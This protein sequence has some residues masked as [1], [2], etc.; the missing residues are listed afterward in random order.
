MDYCYSHKFKTKNYNIMKTKSYLFLIITFLLS[1]A[2]E[3]QAQTNF[4]EDFNTTSARKIP[5]TWSINE[6][7]VSGTYAW[8][9]QKE[10][11]DAMC[12]R[13]N[14]GGGSYSVLRTPEITLTSDKDLSFYFK[15]ETA[16]FSVYVDVLNAD[17]SE[18]RHLLGENLV[19]ASWVLKTFSLKQFTGNKIK[20]AFYGKKTDAG[21]YAYFDKVSI[22]DVSICAYPMDIELVSVS[23]NSASIMWLINSDGSSIPTYFKIRVKDETGTIV[24]DYDDYRFENDG[25]YMFTIEGLNS[26]TLYTVS[27]CSD[28]S[29]D[30]KGVSKWSEDFEFK[31]LCDYVQLPYSADFDADNRLLSPCWIV[32]PDNLAGVEIS[33]KG[34]QYGDTGYSLMFQGST[35]K[36]AYAVSEQFAHA[37]ND[38]EISFMVYGEFGLPFNVGLTT[39]PLS[40]DAFEILVE[41]T[42]YTRSNLRWR[43]V[44]F[45][46]DASY[47]ANQENVS[48]FISLPAGVSGRL[49]VDAVRVN[50][51]PTCPRLENIKVKDILA[52]EVTLEW[53]EYGNA[54][55]YEVEMTNLFDAEASV[56]SKTVTS[57][58]CTI[59]GLVG[60]T[61]YSV[62]VRPICSDTDMGEWS[63]PVEFR[64][65]CDVMESNVFQESFEAS[66][67]TIPECWQVKQFVAG[68]GDGENYGNEGIDVYTPTYSMYPDGVT[69]TEARDGRKVLRFRKTKGGTRTAIITQAMQ[70][71]TPKS[72]DVSFW[73]YRNTR[74]I[75]SSAG[76]KYPEPI[77]V[78]VNTRPDTVGAI[79]LDVIYACM[80][81]SPT[82]EEPGWYQYDYN[83]PLTGTVYFMLEAI[84]QPGGNDLF[85][86]DIRVY[87]APTCRKIKDIELLPPTQTEF[88]M[89]WAKGND[90][91][92]WVVSYR[93]TDPNTLA[94]IKTDKVTVTGGVPEFKL[95]GLTH[96]TEY[97]IAGK[98]ASYCAV[99]DTSVWVEFDYKFMTE[100]AAISK[101]PYEEQFEGQTFPPVCWSVIGSA[102]DV[103]RHLRTDYMYQG[104]GV[105]F[106]SNNVVLVTPEFNTEA[107]KDYR[108]TFMML[109]NYGAEG[110]GIEVWLN[111]KPTLE[112][113]TKQLF[114]SSDYLGTPSVVQKAYYQY[115]VE[116]A[117]GGSKYL[118]FK[119]VGDNFNHIDNVVFLE[120]PSC[121]PILD[122]TVDN[123]TSYTARVSVL[124]EGVTTCE[125]SFCGVGVAPNAGKIVASNDSI[126]E[127]N[128]L[129]SETTYEVYVRNVCGALKGEWSSK[130]VTITT[131][132]TP[133][134]VTKATP[135]NEDF[136]SFQEAQQLAG[137]YLS[138][139]G[140]FR[141]EVRDNTYKSMIANSGRLYAWMSS[142]VSAVLYRPLKL[143]AGVYYE[144]S[145][146]AIQGGTSSHVSLGYARVPVF[147]SL[148]YVATQEKMAQEWVNHQ[149][150]F[151]VP[152]TG[153][154]YLG[155]YVYAS[156]SIGIDDIR[157]Q[158]VSCVPP[159]TN[160]ANLASNSAAIKITDMSAG[161]WL[162]S[163]NNFMFAPDMVNGNVFYGE[164][165]EEYTNLENLDPNSEY[166]YSVK[167]LCGEG[168]ESTWSKV[169]SFRT[170][171]ASQSLPFSDGFE[172]DVNCWT[173]LGDYEYHSL[174]TYPK[175]EGNQSLSASKAVI[176]TPE[177][178]VESLADYMIEGWIRSS[179]AD[180]D[181]AIGVM[182]DINDLSTYETVGTF[183]IQENSKWYHMS[184]YFSDLNLPDY[185]DF[186]NARYVV[187][188]LPQDEVSCFLDDI[189]IKLAPNCKQPVEVKLVDVTDNSCTISWTSKGE[190]T[191][192]RVVGKR[193]E[194]ISV[195]TVVTSNPA[196]IN[197]LLHSTTYDFEISSICSETESSAVTSIGKVT[198][199]CGLWDLPYVED[200]SGYSYGA[201]PLCWENLDNGGWFVEYDNRIYFPTNEKNKEGQK[202]TILT[203]KFNL[204]DVEGALLTMS[205]A[206]SYADTLTI[207]LSTDGGATY[208]IVLGEGYKNL[209]D[210][211]V[212]KFDLTPYV[213]NEIRISIEGTAS[214]IET[215]YIVINHFEIEKIESCM[216]PVGLTLKSVGGT[217]AI[218]EINDTT[219]AT[220][221]QYA[222]L[223]SNEY[224]E[225]VTEFTT[226]TTNPF[227]I[228]NLGGFTDYTLYVRTDCGD[229]QSSWRNIS[230]TTECAEVNTVP[231]FDGFEKIERPQEGCFSILTTKPNGVESWRP[232]T[233][234][235]Y[236]K[237]S[238]G[239][240]SLELFPSD[241]YEMFVVM[242]QLDAPTTSL[243]MT[244]DYL[245]QRSSYYAPDIV[246]GVL[247]DA[248]NA[249]TFEEVT[250]CVSFEPR[251]DVNDDVIFE[252]VKVEF[253]VLDAE[254]SNSRIAFKVGPTLYNQGEAYIDN[255]KI[256]KVDACPNVRSIELLEVD[257]TSARLALQY[258]SDAVQLAYGPAVQDI[259]SML[260]VV[261]TLDTIELTDLTKGVNYA[262][263]ARSVCGTD[264]GAWIH[265]LT[266][267]TVCD[268]YIID[269]ATMYSESFNSYEEHPMAFPACY[270][271][272]KTHLELGVEYPKLTKARDGE[273]DKN[274][275]H[276]YK[277]VVLAL[278]EFNLSGERLML[279]FNFCNPDGGT[280]YK[281]GL[282]EDL[283]DETTFMEVKEFYASSLLRQVTIDFSQYKVSGK[284]IV[285]KGSSK[286]NSVY[287]DNIVVSK[288]P[289]CFAPTDLKLKALGDTFAIFDWNHAPA[290]IK[291]ECELSSVNGIEKFDVDTT[292][293][294][295]TLNNLARNTK[296]VLRMRAVCV[297]AT[298]WVEVQFTTMNNIPTFPYVCGFE[299]VVE[300]S[301]WLFADKGEDVKFI[302]GAN[303][304]NS[305][306]TGDSALYIA[307]ATRAYAYYDYGSSNVYAYRTLLFDSGNYQI[308][309][310]WKCNGESE[311]DFG[312]VFLAPTDIYVSAGTKI[313]AT[314][315][316]VEK[317]IRLHESDKLLGSPV[318]K[319]ESTMVSVE[320]MTNYYLIVQWSNDVSGAMNPPLSIDNI[321]IVKIECGV[322]S[323][324]ALRY[325]ATDSAVID[326]NNPTEG[327]EV[328]YVVS[329]TGDVESVFTSGVVSGDSIALSGL[330]ADTQYYLFVRPVCGDEVESPW[331]SLSFATEC[332]AVEVK[333]GMPYLENFE[334]YSSTDVFDNCWTEEHLLGTNRWMVNSVDASVVAYAY[335]G[336]NFMS[337]SSR[338][339]K[340]KNSVTRAFMLEG[341]KYYKVSVYAC[342]SDRVA[343]YVS[344]ISGG[345][346]L[347][348]EA[349][350]GTDYQRV[351]A[352]IYVETSGVYELG[353]VGEVSNSSWNLIID[354]FSVEALKVGTP[355][356]LQV[357]EVTENSVKL[358]WVGNSEAYEVEVLQSGISVATQTTNTP[359]ATFVGLQ[360]STAYE[361]RV[362]AVYGDEMSAWITINFNTVCGVVYPPFVQTFE[363]TQLSTIPLCWDNTTESSLL[364]NMYN[365]A[366]FEPDEYSYIGNE[367]GRCVRIQCASTNGHSMLMTPSIS[368]DGDYSLSFKYLSSSPNE[369]LKV[370]VVYEGGADT[371][372]VFGNTD[373]IWQSVRYGLSN[374]KGKVVKLGFYATAAKASSAYIV[375]DDVRV[376][377]Y[378]DNIVFEDAICQP[379]QG[380]I[381]YNKYGFT[382][383]SS[384]LKIGENIIEK[385]FEAQS[386]SEC[387]TLKTLKLTMNTSGVYQYNDTIC[388]GEVY[389]KAPF[390]GKNIVL[391]G[392]YDALLTSSCGCDS[393]VRLNLTVLNT[394]YS[395]EETIC[396]GDAYTLGKKQLTE[397]G[398]YVDTLINSRGCD[399]VVTLTLNVMPKYF[400]T[401]RYVCQGNKVE[402]IDTVLTT[403]GRYQRVFE[404]ANGCDSVVIMD[405]HVLPSEV[406]VYDTIC[407][408]E[409]Y[410]FLDTIISESG[411]YVRTFQNILRCDSTVYLHLTVAEPEPTIE[412]DYICQG[413]LYTGYG[414][415][416]ITITQDTMLIQ[417]I[418]Q[419][420]RC[421]SLVHIYVDY[422]E[423]VE[424]DTTVF[425]QQGD[426]Y[427]FGE[428]T[429]TKPGYY[430]EV[431]TSSA[432]C[433]SIV[434]LTL[435]VGTGLEGVYVLSL[436][437][438]PNPISGTE[439]TYI[440]HEWTAEQ[441]QGLV[442]EVIDATGKV[443]RRQQPM[444]YPIA[445]ESL[446]T[447][448]IYLVRVID[449]I[450]GLHIGRIVVR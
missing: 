156:T 88:R 256:E 58:P 214:G 354:D 51:R 211:V 179:M 14:A 339:G 336:S 109:R 332:Y 431:F 289:E 186:K 285:F 358:T 410:Q 309:F 95:E 228:E 143:K 21:G 127:V 39:D 374:Y 103:V 439:T 61:T 69:V 292:T 37:A 223:R 50:P 189:S 344:L 357:E 268:A 409:D 40:P 42:I 233:G 406:E 306:M 435:E 1:L 41:D 219:G 293:E 55:K 116:F 340:H 162:L 141:T 284:Y 434:N 87:N 350:I 27:L 8:R 200:F 413:E 315:L 67:S 52:Q 373:N 198:T 155:V 250:T 236:S 108:M 267:G 149:G 92:S 394:H 133:F 125:V 386:V 367:Y 45:C 130:K 324:L 225:N 280:Y 159:T 119:N 180:I 246:V 378:V 183:H 135:F 46:T 310:D 18:T 383:N 333:E 299:D 72:Y 227:T 123:V 2:F 194:R 426:Y 226:I 429:L 316:D 170:R 325:V 152:E 34:F 15:N 217:S 71:N 234:I 85:V 54:G 98:V 205:F 13:F 342:Q 244:F 254:F 249:S 265:P 24:G 247:K 35:T 422:V 4:Y 171:C 298:N 107:G 370:V 173:F 106:E 364:E 261:S 279:T 311:R 28:C 126:I 352:E 101:L 148:V 91:T 100:C 276:L 224:L 282:Q 167:S 79:E 327:G 153:V 222:C 166:Y 32:N 242:P 388:Q 220:A 38:L 263:Y 392:Y 132:C 438:A 136:E 237:Y 36:T 201:T 240:H 266:F 78:L 182:T 96:S 363:N 221:W 118:M 157:V 137:C 262:V 356:D 147:D 185:A 446:P 317:Y 62:K 30:M 229:K 314:E 22:E 3:L 218:V 389:N 83:I 188:Y 169:E 286:T 168:E 158:E 190:E 252:T 102:D 302:V 414:H 243:Q 151:Q 122:F 80:Y 440:N 44:R 411:L 399:S 17:G 376:L 312:R 362:R 19:S 81:H 294:L 300:N 68:Y 235:S 192:W 273:G 29:E 402:W 396:E 398:I 384:S 160:I 404:N 403:T 405:L 177:L 5:S 416:R 117:G 420:D 25:S 251:R 369:K 346:E 64:T 381:T 232:A 377:C 66:S 213:G 215:S 16:D 142:G 9:G 146:Y 144:L 187:F 84:A 425:I 428:N 163:V 89:K 301:N 395:L 432:G 326:F 150:Y 281:V 313:G 400:E 427:D 351:S 283:S 423:V 443:V 33:S 216:R 323:D 387:D 207:R 382:V 138:E 11:F 114:I 322:I 272:I 321:R 260:R 70:I 348:R 113:A 375:V 288:A 338:G 318:W 418:S 48:L 241:E 401:Q 74:E 258:M 307:D 278:P 20:I 337:L 203:P 110:S 329:L 308:T 359:T 47:Y 140:Y 245:S 231:Y 128:G 296:Y 154:Y 412:N 164:V 10:D 290:A 181:I 380:S 347:V 269:D 441:M 328:E 239:V 199:G 270:T 176:V 436:V 212:R 360:P 419:P 361:A 371:L 175:Q 259:D 131:H 349:I 104:G 274:V 230:F 334:T 26:S 60:N 385:L 73:M 124:D 202:A 121:E 112:G 421:D 444:T 77:R 319:G 271:R 277:D 372:G 449:G 448:G 129:S 193:G 97:R 75:V 368:L 433:D 63:V 206:N 99:G 53:K 291:Y 450:G 303:S 90:E 430:R 255:I 408:G 196:V 442:F 415:S 111:D 165:T 257:A 341:G 208:P 295:L 7:E 330:S 335:S 172:Y 331:A 264:T 6:G 379:S 204:K 86:D 304:N 391:S 397:A 105:Q 393:I 447:S 191:S 115:K 320:D 437:I 345:K 93:L 57:Y 76:N 238:E 417:R 209:P 365:W 174:T 424:I 12:M 195:D 31:T 210:Y 355:V 275:L 161:K 49:Y 82:V 145:T 59:T 56:I 43:E 178:E 353:V 94:T 390:E 139:N 407:L 134:E 248:N 197:G 65:G 366:V 297:E 305:V 287:I 120:K 343:A 23:Q 184:M 253:N 445:I